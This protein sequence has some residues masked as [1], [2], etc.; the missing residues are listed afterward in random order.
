MV[1]MGEGYHNFHH[2]FASDYRNG[3]RWYHWDPSKWVITLL[4]WCGQTKKLYRTSPSRILA[5]RTAAEHLRLERALLAGESPKE[6]APALAAARKHY[7]KLKNLLAELEVC[8]REYRQA[9]QRFSEK[10]RIYIRSARWQ[11]KERRLA[12]AQA[13]R[14]WIFFINTHPLIPATARV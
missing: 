13:R 10:S 8:E 2:Q 9:A 7:E 4:S 6:T 1:T 5:A 12:L 14:D 11:L 3:V